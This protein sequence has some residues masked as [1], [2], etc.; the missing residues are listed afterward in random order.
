[1]S[2]SNADA[3]LAPVAAFA[4]TAL[5]ACEDRF[6]A[7]PTPLLAN[8][9]DPRTRRPA[10]LPAGADVGEG[11]LISNLANQLNFLRVLDGLSALTGDAAPRERALAICRFALRRNRRRGMLLWGN[12]AA[13]DLRTQRPV[14][15]SIKG[16][17]HELKSHYPPY[18]LLWQA[19]AAALEDAI[20]CHWHGHMYDWARLDFSRHGRMD[21]PDYRLP[22]DPWGAPYAGGDPFFIGGGLTFLNAG[23]DLYYAAATLARL[24]GR[25]GPMEWAL[26]LLRRYEATR[27]PRTGMGGYTFSCIFDKTDP[28]RKRNGDRAHVQFR[29][30]FP[31]H[32]PLEGSLSTGGAIWTIIGRSAL[33][34]LQLARE[35]G[36]EHGA[37]FARSA[38]ADLLAYGRSCY[39]PAANLF[40]PTFTDGFRLT[41]QTMAQD[42]YYGRA[43]TRFAPVAADELLLWSH[44]AAW[45]ACRDA[46]LWLTARRIARHRGIGDI[47]ASPGDTPRLAADAP[48]TPEGCF[49]LLELERE[50]PGVGYLDG[51]TEQA[52]GLLR[53]RFRD[54]WF[55]SAPDAFISLD[56]A[57]PIAFLHVAAHLAG[58]PD[59]APPYCS[60]V[61]LSPAEGWSRE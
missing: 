44:L 5:A 34:R 57:E 32:T 10:F 30:Q 11:I 22:A 38:A 35:L 58:K 46:Q 36:V 13:V 41:G 45:R 56:A 2:G 24:S 27:H 42:G 48:G 16:K 49:A 28:E 6:G 43:G 7:D 53:D 47:G 17:V 15:L 55:I 50:F 39:E 19:D 12:H 31:E 25:P 8:G 3:F 26:R 21:L 51:A 1:M 20:A 18:D 60:N 59:A 40:H 61:A 52:R 54:G 23:S 37:P 14:F 33:C 9:I 29:D 4:Q